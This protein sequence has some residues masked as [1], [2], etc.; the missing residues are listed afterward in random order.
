M[1]LTE[2]AIA[3]CDALPAALTA[4]QQAFDEHLTLLNTL[5][6]CPEKKKVFL[7]FA[8]M[9]TKQLAITEIIQQFFKADTDDQKKV[10]ILSGTKP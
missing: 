5:P 1:N 8:S 6:D 10:D 7:N 3:L 9:C 4:Q 2:R